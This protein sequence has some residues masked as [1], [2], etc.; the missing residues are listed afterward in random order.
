MEQ[1][2]VYNLIDF[3]IPQVKKMLNPTNPHFDAYSTAQGLFICP[4]D[5]NTERI[6]SENNYRSNFG[7]STPAAGSRTGNADTAYDELPGDEWPVGGNGAF[8]VSSLG[9]NKG[10]GAK[11]YTDGLS[12]TAFF[13]EAVKG[14]GQADGSI[15]V[16]GD[17][18]RCP[19]NGFDPGSLASIEAAFQSGANYTPK[20]EGFL[21][22]GS[23]RWLP[24][25]DWS[26]GWPFA[27]Y[28]STQYNHVA[29]PNWQGQ[30]CGKNSIN[31]TTHE[32]AIMPASSDH[33]GVVV[34]AFG[35]GHTDQVSDSVDLAVW[36][37]IGTREAAPGE[38][39]D[40]SL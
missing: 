37:A 24:G 28:D 6:I 23:G 32:H 25:D 18:I 38:T 22:G 31:D 26:N 12:N 10:L 29:P 2:N 33:P 16:K 30:S 27:G 20:S 5:A 11:A 4:S 17:I 19:A 15:P 8:T 9:S 34:V 1:S 35:D 21:F 39:P 13:S 36:R 14:S 3:D 40:T 7:G